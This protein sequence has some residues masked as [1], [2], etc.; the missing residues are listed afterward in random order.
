MRVFGKK[1]RIYM[2]Y[3]SATPTDLEV[4]SAMAKYSEDNFANPSALHKEGMEAKNTLKNSR[5]NISKILN[6]RSTEIIF[7]GG[8]TESNNLALMGVF[9]A[10]LTSGISKPH[11]ITTNIEHPAILNVCDEIE[12][13]GGEIT[14]V[15]VLEDGTVSPQDIYNEIKENTVLITIMYANNEIGTIQPIENIAKKIKNWKLKNKS[16]HNYPYFHTDACQAGLYLSLNISTLGVDLLTLDGIKIYGP[17]GVG[18]LYIKSNTSISPIVLGGGQERGLRSGTENVAGIV[19]LAKSIEIAESLKKSES[20]RLTVI[21]DYGIDQI[22]LNFPKAKL[23]G[24]KENRLPNNINICFPGMDSEFMVVALD[25]AGISASYS[26]ACK[27][28]D[29]DSSSFVIKALGREECS[30]SSLRFSF[31]R[32]TQK[33]DIDTLITVLRKIVI[34]L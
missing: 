25:V 7:T 12:K 19:G 26:S 31:G 16:K 21:R 15:K 1:K 18:L 27:T 8:G 33:K 13:M 32:D 22:L 5:E 9:K 4:F 2:D 17:A 23:N 29:E 11:I 20:E 10:A 34:L 6:T 24:S 28:M 3:A 30:L 14:R